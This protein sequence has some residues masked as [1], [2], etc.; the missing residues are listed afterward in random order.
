MGEVVI[1]DG[2]RTAHGELLG[3]LS[4]QTAVDLGEAAVQGL[5]DRNGPGTG[6]I[7]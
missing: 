7:D 2:A 1:V 3:A 6:R 5:L 4:G